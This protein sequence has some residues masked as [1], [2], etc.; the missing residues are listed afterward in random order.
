MYTKLY[1]M[2]A[3]YLVYSDIALSRLASEYT[4]CIQ[5]VYCMQRIQ[6]YNGIQYTTVCTPPLNS[7]SPP[8]GLRRLQTLHTARTRARS[9]RRLN[10]LSG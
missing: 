1:T 8:S 3:V 2:F 10:S 6:V 4:D 5:T 7:A 9:A